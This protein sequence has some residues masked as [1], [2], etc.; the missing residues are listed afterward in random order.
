MIAAV[1][2]GLADLVNR[3]ASLVRRGLPAVV[4]VTAGAG[5]PE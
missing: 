5:C 1:L 2:E 4:P 3:D